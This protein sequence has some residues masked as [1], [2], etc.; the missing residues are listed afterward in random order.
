MKV[1]ASG[2]PVGR[3]NVRRSMSRAS[4]R[5]KIHPSA[6]GCLARPARDR[7]V[8]AQGRRPSARATNRRR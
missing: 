4:A 7:H 2:L 5:I 8:G 1:R 6:L 3:R